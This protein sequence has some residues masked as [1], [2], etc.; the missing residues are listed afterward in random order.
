MGRH[1]RGSSYRLGKP[2][3]LG[4]RHTAGNVL[5][6]QHHAEVTYAHVRH[7]C[8]S[9]NHMLAASF[10]LFDPKQC[11]PGKLEKDT[12]VQVL[13]GVRLANRPGPE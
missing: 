13:H 2:V 4:K 8:T 10:S 11:A 3:I 7:W 1:L 5:S 6:F 12:E 9:G